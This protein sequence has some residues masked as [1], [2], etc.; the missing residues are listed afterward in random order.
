MSNDKVQSTREAFE[1]WYFDKFLVRAERYSLDPEQYAYPHTRDTWEGWQA[2]REAIAAPGESQGWKLIGWT[3]FEGDCGRI[4]DEP[5]DALDDFTQAVY[6]MTNVPTA[7]QPTPPASSPYEAARS[8]AK[9]LNERPNR[10]IDLR[11]VAMLVHHV[12]S[13]PVTIKGGPAE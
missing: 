7:E 5:P 4:H 11:D 1:A 10:P 8:L 6:V 2:G 9:W 13:Q 3:C 12:Q